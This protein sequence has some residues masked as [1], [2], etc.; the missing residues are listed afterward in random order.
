M[1]NEHL[2]AC[3]RSAAEAAMAAA[4]ALGQENEVLRRLV[5]DSFTMEVFEKIRGVLDIHTRKL[6]CSKL[7]ETKDEWEQRATEN[8]RTIREVLRIVEQAR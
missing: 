1:N 8:E 4:K 6:T 7:P 3:W 2:A 5:N